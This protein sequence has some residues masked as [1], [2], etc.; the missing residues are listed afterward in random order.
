MFNRNPSTWLRFQLNPVRGTKPLLI[1]CTTICIGTATTKRK[2]FLLKQD[3]SICSS[4]HPNK[5][6]CWNPSERK[7]L[8]LEM[9]R[10]TKPSWTRQPAQQPESPVKPDGPNSRRATMEAI[11]RKSSV[12]VCVESTYYPCS[13]LKLKTHT[14]TQT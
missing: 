10:Y 9:W 7:N 13:T 4:S 14:H 2:T 12:C 6:W 3:S 8:L 5:A 11:E 1:T